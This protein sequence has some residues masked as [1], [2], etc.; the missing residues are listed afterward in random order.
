MTKAAAFL[1]LSIFKK[2][3]EPPLRNT[4]WQLVVSQVNAI[5]GQPTKSLS[6]FRT[7]QGKEV[8]VPPP[9]QPC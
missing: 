1:L 2:R 6:N 7:S 9:P 3:P 4:V 5:L 8:W